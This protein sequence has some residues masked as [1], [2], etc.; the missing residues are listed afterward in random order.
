LP[1]FAGYEA[2]TRS[3]DYCLPVECAQFRGR[4]LVSRE[5]IS[6]GNASCKQSGNRAV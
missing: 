1:K 2:D 3:T 4:L 5:Q 6:Q